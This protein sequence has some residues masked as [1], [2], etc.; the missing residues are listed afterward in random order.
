M[1]IRE[2]AKTVG[3]KVEGRLKRMAEFE[4][5][6]EDNSTPFRF[7]ADEALNEYYKFADGSVVIVTIDGCVT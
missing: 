4:N 5:W 3:V 6:K 7:Y 2:Y 1:T